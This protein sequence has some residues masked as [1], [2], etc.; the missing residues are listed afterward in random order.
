LGLRR[1]VA[2]AAL[3][4][5][6]ACGGEDTATIY[7]V[8]RLGPDGPPGQIAP[9]LMPVER[10]LRTGISTPRQVALLVRQGPAPGE[11]GQGFVVT[12]D[13]RTRVRSVSVVD[14]TATVELAGREPDYYGSAALV[15]SLTS[16]SGVE[17][18]RLRLDGQPCCV[19]AHSG[20][21][22]EALTAKSFAAWQGEP[23]ALRSG[24]DAVSCRERP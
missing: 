4:T 2:L 20:R 15:Y 13:P 14:S 23:C 7:L 1:I 5:L 9:V 6:A 21:P 17:T 24:V 10:S 11:W 16:L 3:L 18:V 22:V 8:Q 12:I 19:Y